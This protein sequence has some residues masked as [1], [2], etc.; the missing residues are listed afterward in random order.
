M[1]LCC[2]LIATN[3]LD[4]AEKQLKIIRKI[5]AEDE[6][7]KKMERENEEQQEGVV[8]GEHESMKKSSDLLKLEAQFAHAKKIYDAKLRVMEK[9]MAA[10]LFAND[11]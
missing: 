8:D 7:R 3:R 9:K 4:E 1:R 11:S 2:A 6:R 5:K 10:G